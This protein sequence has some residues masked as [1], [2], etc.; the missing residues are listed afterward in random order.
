MGIKTKMVLKR[1]T[2]TSDTG[3]LISWQVTFQIGQWC[4]WYPQTIAFI[5]RI[6]KGTMEMK[7]LTRKLLINQ[8]TQN[9]SFKIANICLNF[10]L[11]QIQ[12]SN[13]YQRG[14]ALEISFLNFTTYCFISGGSLK[15][16]WYKPGNPAG[17]LVSCL[18]VAVLR[19]YNGCYGSDCKE[20]FR[21]KKLMK[22]LMLPWCYN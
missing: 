14:L 12:H 9:S 1:E 21:E 22:K 20:Y 16:T 18:L 13:V 6:D 17:I 4:Q 7:V 2:N 8:R 11:H 10:F 5:G 15:N 19:N 3:L